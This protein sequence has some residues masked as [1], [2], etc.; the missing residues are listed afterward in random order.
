MQVSASSVPGT[1]V[2]ET[3]PSSALNQLQQ[4]VTQM[5]TLMNQLITKGSPSTPEDHISSSMA[6]PTPGENTGH[7]Y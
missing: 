7:W 6:G 5:A 4:Q 3:P 2:K 1:N